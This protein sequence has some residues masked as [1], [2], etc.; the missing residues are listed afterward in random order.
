[1]GANVI[2]IGAHHPAIAAGQVLVVVE[3]VATEVTDEAYDLVA[4]TCSPGLGTVLDYDETMLSADLHHGIHVA[5]ISAKMNGQN[6]ARLRGNRGA[7]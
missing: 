1:M 2:V 6:T 4:V 7:N 5:R 3:G